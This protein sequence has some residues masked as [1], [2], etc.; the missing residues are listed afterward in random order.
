VHGAKSPDEVVLLE[1]PTEGDYDREKA[2][3]ADVLVY[4]AWGRRPPI[5]AVRTWSKE[6][7][8]FRVVARALGP[9]QPIYS[10]APPDFP[11]LE[12]YPRTT[13][14]WVELLL[15]LVRRLSLPR[16]IVL[17]GWSFGGVMALELAERL[18]TEGAT[19]ALVL[20]IDTRKPKS[21]PE[22]K[23]GAKMPVRLR[24]LA[25]QLLEYCELETR[26]ERR[27]YLWARVDPWRGI[28]KRRERRVRRAAR[29][30]KKARRSAERAAKAERA[31][32]PP[33]GLIVTRFTGERMTFLQ[34]T[35]HDAYLKYASH[36]T[37]LPLALLRTEESMQRAGDDPALGWWPLAR[38]SFLV[39][40]V[41]GTHWTIFDPEHIESLA[42]RI[43]RA[44]RLATGYGLE[45]GAASGVDRTASASEGG[46]IP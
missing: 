20:M 31:A 9:D 2:A 21:R 38:G 1:V 3:A 28:A 5:V 10:L 43:D 41:A 45:V 33:E 13:D 16:E 26:R 6:G 22:T 23:P 34:R 46:G 18:S 36:P 39:E 12:D 4:N 27:D 42:P 40:G 19:I 17:A 11:A 44:L 8:H 35:I 25:R 14:E 30:E 32:A 7:E 37:H 24:K 29:S 15:P